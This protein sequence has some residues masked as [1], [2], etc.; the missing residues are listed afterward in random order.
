MLQ[1]IGQDPSYKLKGHVCGEALDVTG[2]RMWTQTSTTNDDLQFKVWVIRQRRVNK[3]TTV[4]NEIFKSEVFQP[5]HNGPIEIKFDIDFSCEP[6]DILSLAF[7][8]IGT[9]GAF[10]RYLYPDATTIL[11]RQP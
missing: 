1:N 3:S 11:T 9:A 6:G 10:T 7:E 8:R 4:E 5:K 2:F